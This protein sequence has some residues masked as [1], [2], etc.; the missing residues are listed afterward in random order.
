MKISI[1]ALPDKVI[2]AFVAIGVLLMILI[3]AFATV[4]LITEYIEKEIR[5]KIVSQIQTSPEL[6]FSAVVILTNMRLMTTS[7]TS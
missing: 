2:Q 6:H 4:K 3:T 7:P 5:R 1:T